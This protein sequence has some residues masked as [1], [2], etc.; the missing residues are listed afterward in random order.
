ML[1][2]ALK[3]VPVP[4]APAEVVEEHRVACLRVHPMA[5]ALGAESSENGAS[6]RIGGLASMP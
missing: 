1:H 2:H 6:G 3:T 4:A 5:V